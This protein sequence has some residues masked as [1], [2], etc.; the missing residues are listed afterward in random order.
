M[1]IKLL[2]Q[3]YR[4]PRKLCFPS[5]S[6]QNWLAGFTS[7]TKCTP[8]HRSDKASRRSSLSKTTL[9]LNTDKFLDVRGFPAIVG[10]RPERIRV[11]VKPEP[12]PLEQPSSS[13][14]WSMYCQHLRSCVISSSSL[15]VRPSSELQSRATGLHMTRRPWGSRL[16][17]SMSRMIT[18]LASS[19]R[20]VKSCSRPA[21]SAGTKTSPY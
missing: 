8:K 9:D 10:N 7:V 21:L 6:Y 18:G 15:S 16:P 11:H 14:K 20:R 2:L 13:S 4:L 1:D 19:I 12:I 17:C 5:V 3:S